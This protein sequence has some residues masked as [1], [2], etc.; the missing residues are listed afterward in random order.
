MKSPAIAAA[1][2]FGTIAATLA[3]GAPP[4][5]SNG[6]LA[7]NSVTNQSCEVHGCTMTLIDVPIRYGLIR[8]S[9][10]YAQASTQEFPHTS[11]AIL[12]GCVPKKRTIGQK[13]VCPQCEQARLSW[14]Q[15]Q[16]T[17]QNVKN[18]PNGIKHT[19]VPRH[20]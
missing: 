17:L 2:L 12:G 11:S 4:S 5:H 16:H 19:E 15:K 10:E 1:V 7:V 20:D 9:P 3:A 18:T 8:L 6:V 14:N 13:L